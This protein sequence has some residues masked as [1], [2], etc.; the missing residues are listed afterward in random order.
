MR[1]LAVTSPIQVR[2]GTPLIRPRFAGPPGAP[3]PASGRRIVRALHL[4]I[5]CGSTSSILSF[6]RS[7][8]RC[9]LWS[10][11][12]RRGFSRWRREHRSAT[13]P[14]PGAPDRT[15]AD[16]PSLLRPGDVLVVN[17][18]RV[19]PARLT[20][21]RRAR[22]QRGAHRGDPRQER[23]LRSLARLPET[24]EK[25]GRRRDDRLRPRRRPARC[26]LPR[27]PWRGGGPPAFSRSPARRSTRRCSATARCRLPPYIAG[28]RAIDARDKADYQTIFA[29]NGGR[30]RPRPRRAC[31]SRRICWRRSRCA[32]SRSHARR[33]T[34]GAGTFLP[35]KAED[36]D[37]HRMHAEWGRIDDATAAA[38]NAAREGGGRIVAA[39]TTSLRLLESAARENGGIAPFEG[40]T[41]IFIAPGYR[42]RAVRCFAH[43]LPSAA[44]DPV[45]AG[46]GLRGGLERMQAAY[47]HAIASGYRFYSYGD[48]CFLTRAAT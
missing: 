45:H 18:T 31:I 14:S 21:V 3:S 10:R 24:R 28:K 30:R 17:D 36:T 41:S 19:I 6:P 11:A 26:G 20:G 42:F 4:E 16:L 25:G 2:A 7:A 39:G 23:R 13:A 15:I 44:L 8:S 22:G 5:P 48:A 12:R 32:A 47:A 27:A 34:S 33:C 46:R 43:Q 37:D 9:A 40:E 1:G 29:R 38:I 35:V